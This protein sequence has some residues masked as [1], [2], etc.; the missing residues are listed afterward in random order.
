MHVA[1]FNNNKFIM[2]IPNLK[3]YPSYFLRRPDSTLGVEGQQKT[4]TRT[5]LHLSSLVI[6][7]SNGN[8]KPFR[9]PLGNPQVI[10]DPLMMIILFTNYSR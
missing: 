8:K 9:L 1:N 4:D 2:F 5:E 10:N 3:D 7:Q 6:S